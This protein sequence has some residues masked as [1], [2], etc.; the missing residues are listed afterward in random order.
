MFA[1]FCDS[2][3]SRFVPKVRNKTIHSAKN[4]SFLIKKSPVP[5]NRAL[6]V[7]DIKSGLF[8]INSPKNE[9]LGDRSGKSDLCVCYN[10]GEVNHKVVVGRVGYCPGCWR[11][12]NCIICSQGNNGCFVQF[13]EKKLA[14]FDN[15]PKNT[16]THWWSRCGV[17]GAV[18][19]GPNALVVQV[20]CHRRSTKNG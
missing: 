5:K 10:I 3:K 2:H 1:G 8:G 13:S 11:A 12:C 4:H 18:E 20:W 9:S 19:A 17:T 14:I 15:F 7:S 16:Q 6:F